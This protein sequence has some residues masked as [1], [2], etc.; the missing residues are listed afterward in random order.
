MAYREISSD[1]ITQKVADLCAHVAFNLPQDTLCAL[2]R[3]RQTETSPLGQN[4]LEK[5]L[6]NATL[7]QKT[8][9]PLCQDTGTA[10]FDVKIGK[11]VIV[12]GRSISEAIN[13]GVRQA[14]TKAYLRKS[15]VADPLYDR[16]NTK[17]NTPAV[18]HYTFTDGDQIQI[19]FA[20][21][22]GGAENMSAIKMMVPA[23]GEQGVI[24]FVIDTVQKAGGNPCPPIVVGVG[25]GGNFELCALTAKRA[26]MR[27][28]NS[29]NPNPKYATLEKLLLEKINALGI[30]PQGL[31][32]DT[33]A[34]AVHIET[35]PAHIASFPVAININCHSARHGELII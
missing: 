20:P 16:V 2:Q 32:G 7:S 18:I 4:I 27:P 19:H 23:D 17:D 25:I 24:D 14:Y 34:L 22:G 21:K 28:T 13:D 35:A 31:G 29:E 10:V 30:G 5:C 11:D 1:T 33:T 15:I 3:G 9:V 12:T 6:E 8:L 26:L